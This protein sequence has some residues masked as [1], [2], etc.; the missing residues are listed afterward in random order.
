MITE[1]DFEDV[2]MTSGEVTIPISEYEGR[3]IIEE[4]YEKTYCII[5]ISGFAYTDAF[6]FIGLCRI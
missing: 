4:W 1:F 5:I 3:H 2:I 6:S